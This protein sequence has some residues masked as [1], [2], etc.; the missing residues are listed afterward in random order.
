[1]SELPPEQ[2]ARRRRQRR[3]PASPEERALV[4]RI[5]RFI[6]ANRLEHE[7]MLIALVHVC[8]YFPGVKLESAIVAYVFRTILA[9]VRE[10]LQ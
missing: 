6:V 2:V 1:M 8:R 10:V 4:R 5:A 9:P 3:P 7:P